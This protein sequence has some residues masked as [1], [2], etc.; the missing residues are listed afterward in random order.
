MSGDIELECSAQCNVKHLHASAD[1]QDRQ[2]AIQC[3]WNCIEFPAISNRIEIGFE[4]TRVS[5]L[6]AEELRSN[7]RSAGEQQPIRF[8]KAASGFQSIANP[9]LG[10][11]VEK[12]LEPFFV[13]PSQPG[14]KIRHRKN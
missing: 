6:L 3:L 13:F 11:G 9:D 2:T 8:A 7:V 12:R 1:C 14:G 4:D 10:M 5:D